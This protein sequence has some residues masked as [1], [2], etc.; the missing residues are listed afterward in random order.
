MMNI[1]LQ[2]K[3]GAFAASINQN[4][5]PKSQRFTCLCDDCQTYA[6]AIGRPDVL[7]CDGGTQIF[8]TTPASFKISKGAE[9]LKCLRLS[10]KGMFRFYTSCCNTPIANNPPVVKMPYIGVMHSAFNLKSE[11][12][13]EELLGPVAARI[14]GKFGTKPLL[15]GTHEGTPISTILTI[16][17]FLTLAWI[18]GRQN[19]SPFLSQD[20]SAL[21]ET[22]VLS[23][24]E[25]EKLRSKKP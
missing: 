11:K 20:G 4:L 9:N 2:C 21:V 1:S 12:E 22:R 15:A 18:R 25:R 17:K 6:H 23:F 24:E 16:V 13:F 3:C 8:P 7:E 14:Q 19:P 5:S 10:P